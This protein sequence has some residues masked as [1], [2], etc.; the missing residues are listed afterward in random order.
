MLSYEEFCKK[1]DALTASFH[2]YTES[3]KNYCYECYK[4]A[5]EEQEGGEKNG[6]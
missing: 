1:A 5:I 4:K 2:R 6:R 3:D